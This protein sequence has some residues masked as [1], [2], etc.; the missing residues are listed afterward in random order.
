MITT[1]VAARAED[2]GKFSKII[3]REDEEEAFSSGD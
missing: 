2:Q 3:L 1:W